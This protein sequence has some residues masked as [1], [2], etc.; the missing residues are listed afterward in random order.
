MRN[1]GKHATFVFFF[2]DWYGIDADAFIAYITDNHDTFRKAI[3]VTE[4]ACQNFVDQ[5]KQCSAED[6]IK[7]M[8]RTQSFMDN[9][10]FVERYAWF[11]AM[12]DMQG[13]NPV[14]PV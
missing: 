3:W 5:S 14:S 12:R 8:N 9:T 6:V 11:G 10:S 1:I 4:W 7:F 2:I 13:V